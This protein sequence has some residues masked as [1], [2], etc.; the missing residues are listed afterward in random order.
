MKFN[1]NYLKSLLYLEN[2]KYYDMV[3]RTNELKL[4]KDLYDELFV[5]L[6]GNFK[7]IKENDLSLSLLIKQLYENSNVY[8]GIHECMSELVAYNKIPESENYKNAVAKINRIYQMLHDD[9]EMLN[10][11]IFNNEKYIAENK[12]MVFDYNTIMFDCKNHILITPHQIDLINE[13]LD[14][15][16]VGKKEQ[17]LILNSIFKFNN[18]IL[19]SNNKSKNHNINDLN[20]ILTFGYEHIEDNSLDY[21]S[22]AYKEIERQYNILNNYYRILEFDI[23]DFIESL[24]YDDNLLQLVLIGILNKLNDDIYKIIEIIQDKE[25]FMDNQIRSEMIGSYNLLV[26]YYKD[27]RKFYD[28]FLISQDE[29]TENVE[30][31]LIYSGNEKAFILTDIKDA[32][33]EYL[34]KILEL[35]ESFKNGTI[36]KKHFGSLNSMFNGFKKLKDDQVRITVKQVEENIWCVFGVA[37]KKEQTG[38]KIYRKLCTRKIPNVKEALEQSLGVEQELKDYINSNF[39]K[40]NR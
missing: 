31:R 14:K 18:N 39:R 35:L 19:R 20:E 26:S 37:I 29:N 32:E 1:L 2:K 7:E 4:I 33:N 40:G 6:K 22:L 27:I 34:P 23:H 28:S 3:N 10:S 5:L 12:K 16:G 9:Y 25:L 21:D 15:Q 13:F 30:R 36:S 24:V 8:D 17:I 11:E 38:N